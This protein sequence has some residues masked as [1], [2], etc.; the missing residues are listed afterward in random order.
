P[1]S[2]SPATAVAGE[3]ARKMPQTGPARTSL[4]QNGA[5]VVTCTLREAIAFSE[6]MAPEHV[7]CDTP[8]VAARL[9]RA[10]TVFVGDASA[11]AS[12][13]YVTG[14]NHVLPTGGAAAARGGLSA[15]DFVRVS[16]VQRLTGA[17]LRAIA[18]HGLALARAAGLH[19]H[20]ESI[21][22]RLQRSH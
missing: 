21:R 19:A 20:A 5:I 6:R 16:T 11:Q 7:V 15:A 12:G 10:G 17:G 14:S 4:A 9:R 22:V 2:R 18:P 1:P 13:D 3:V 8:A